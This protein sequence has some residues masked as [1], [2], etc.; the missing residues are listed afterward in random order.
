M[1]SS[2]GSSQPRNRT[3]GSRI[4]GG[5]FTS[6]CCYCCLVS[7][8]C[9]T[10]CNPMNCIAFQAS[11]SME[12]SRQEYWSGLTFLSSGDLANPGV[13]PM[14]P[15]LAGGVFTAEPTGKSLVGYF[16]HKKWNNAIC[17]SMNG[18]RDYYIDTDKDIDHMTSLI[19]GIYSTTQMNVETET[20]SQA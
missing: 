7:K 4:A 5:F 10:L 13:K 20:D 3:Q 16:F 19:Y 18:P 6:I 12:F 11:L 9:R 14:S 2:R 8:S 15:A 1:P 17:S